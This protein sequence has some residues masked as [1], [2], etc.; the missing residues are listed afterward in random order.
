M[1]SPIVDSLLVESPSSSLVFAAVAVLVLPLLSFVAHG[2]LLHRWKATASGWLAVVLNGIGHFCAWTIAFA[3]WGRLHGEV[4]G[5]LPIF[6]LPWLSMG[7]NWQVAIGFGVDGL[8]V[9]MLLVVTGVSSLVHAYSV[10]Y[11]HEDASRT[12][13]FALLSF[14]TFAMLGLVVSTNIAQTFVFWELVG[15]AS[16]LLIGFW[17][18]KPS[19]VAASKKAFI[20]TRFAD[21]FFLAGVILVAGAAGSFDF[22]RINAPETAANLLHS[23]SWFGLSFWQG[24]AL[25]W[26]ALLL[27]AGAWGKSAMFPLHV[28]LPDAMEGPTPVSSLIHSATMVVAGIF[29]VARLFPLM[30]ASPGALTVIEVTGLF[31]ALFA[32]VIACTQTD[33][34]RILAFS[35]LSQLGYMMFCLGVAGTDTAGQ[36]AFSA[37]QFHV[38]THAFFKCLLFLSAGVA[39]HLVHSQELTDMGGLRK[40]LPFTYA[41][42]LIAC[43]AIAGVFPFSGFFSKDSILLATW[44]RGHY[45]T[46]IV[47][48]FTGGLT[49]FYMFRYFITVF[50]GKPQAHARVSDPSHGHA[51]AHREKHASSRESLWMVVP[52]GVLAALTLLV[53]FGEKIFFAW[54]HLPGLESLGHEAERHHVAW[55][56]WVASLVALVGIGGAVYVYGKNHLKPGLEEH[57]PAWYRIIHAKFRVDAVWEYL[58][59]RVLL[60]WVG[61]FVAWFERHVVNGYYDLAAWAL[62]IGALVQ[63]LLQNGHIAR[64]SSLGLIGLGL[65]YWIGKAV[66]R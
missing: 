27:F 10:A 50:H 11:M 54:V 1:D 65:V 26:V 32:A 40:R 49:A 18:H 25:F 42:T 9:M 14:F 7:G 30:S 34:K 35:T 28:W 63:S 41:F 13:F 61:G 16:Y 36:Y 2:L 8:A 45:L 52:M 38:F 58:A 51:D 46:W 4:R 5:L 29:L 37:S 64:Y 59:I 66:A 53:G 17:Y 24:Q 3:T 57:S 55:L 48:L 56:P 33:L 47:A 20:I 31:T 60:Q 43:L 44:N 15:A 23:F 12:R 19:A 6:N 22:N 21:A 39:I 62:R